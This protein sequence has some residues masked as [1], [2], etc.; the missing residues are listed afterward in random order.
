M[1]PGLLARAVPNWLEQIL[2]NYL[3]NAL[4]AAP[5]NSTI[6]IEA[7]QSLR[8]VGIV[9][10]DEGLG[11]PPEHLERAFDRFWR[12]PNAAHEGSGIGLAVVQHLAKLSGGQANLRNRLDRSGLVASVSFPAWDGL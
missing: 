8:Q 12:A 10:T 6:T 9:V 1:V 11:I 4:N 3:D 2:D 7:T 5:D